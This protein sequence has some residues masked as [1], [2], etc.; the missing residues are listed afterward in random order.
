MIVS[1]DH[2]FKYY[3]ADCIL[4]DVC[5]AINEKDRI[6][7]VGANGEG[8]TTLL[9][10]LTGALDYEEGTIGRTNGKVIGYLKQNSGLANGKTIQQEMEAVFADLLALRDEIDALQKKM[11]QVHDDPAA[12]EAVSAEYQKKLARFE[13]RDGY[14][15]EV[16][17]NTILGGMGFGSYDR[18][19]ITDNLSGG[20]KTRLATARLLLM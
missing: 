10:V 2:V 7:L 12:Y 4:R 18:N 14:Q 9:N 1:L 13:A 8:K 11:A 20:E 6:G 16:K 3:G 19:I 15:I 5:A 17:I